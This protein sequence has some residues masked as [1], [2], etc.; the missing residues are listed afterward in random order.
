MQKTKGHHWDLSELH[1]SLDVSETIPILKK[2]ES[3]VQQFS[4]KYKG[5]VT[6]LTPDQINRALIAY[7]DI[8]SRMYKISQFAHLNYAVDL[9]DAAVL[10]FVAKLD[11]FTSLMGNELLFFFLEI[12]TV[13]DQTLKSWLAF[14][15]NQVYA[16]T[17]R[18]AVKKNKYRLS[19]NEEQLINLKDLNGCDALRKL[20]SEHTSQYEFEMV[21]DGQKKIMNGSEC[22]ALRYHADP[23]VRKNAMKLFFEQYKK[24]EHI[25]VHLFNS[26]IKDYNIEREKRGYDSPISIMNIGNDLPN[27]LVDLLHKVTTKSNGLVQRYYTLKKQLLGLDEITLA[28]IYAPVDQDPSEI[29]WEDA[30]AMVLDSFKAFDSEFYDF[31]KDMFDRHRLDVFP[32]KVKRGGAFCSSSSPDVRPFVMLN[33]LGKN[34]DVQT[35]AHELGHAIHAYYSQSQPLI[36]YHAILPVCETASVFCEMLVTDELKKKTSSKTEKIALLATQ[37]EDIF[38]TSHRQNMFSRFEQE[39]HDKIHHQRLSGTELS[40]IYANELKLMFGASVHIPEEYH[41]EWAAIPHMLDVP[42]Y[43]YSYNFGNLLVFGLYQRYLD[44]GD[45]MIPKL[46]RILS[47]GSSKSPVQILADEGIDILAPSFWE[48]SIQ[49]I[50]TVLNEL[51]ALVNT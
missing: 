14:D 9:K 41:W 24:D 38:A 2:I 30:K 4:S 25:M 18:Q 21:I 44:E 32:S 43:V 5:N 7:D 22:R 33:Y 48:Q 47:A 10:R 11:E 27:D 29:N 26:I 40:E 37:L 16:Y 1:D 12:G 39:I 49:L 36:N 31:A 28:D 51:E 8:R 45:T 19:E 23:E 34:R 6:T 15:D 35:L 50:E 13:S 17:L 46:K 20:Y 3:E 42:F